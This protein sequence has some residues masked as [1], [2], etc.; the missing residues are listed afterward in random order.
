MALVVQVEL[1]WEI[2]ALMA[3]MELLP[4]APTDKHREINN[5]IFWLA[6]KL[7]FDF[8]DQDQESNNV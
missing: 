5:N 2:Q 7:V 1:L 8:I 4:T 6:A 3:R